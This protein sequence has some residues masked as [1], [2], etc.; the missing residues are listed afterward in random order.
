MHTELNETYHSVHG[1]IQESRYVFIEKGLEYWLT[2]NQNR[3]VNILEI[4][5]GTALNALLTLQ[6]ARELQVKI[7][8]AALEAYPLARELWGRLNY[9][10]TLGDAEMFEQMHEVP[11]DTEHLLTPA[12]LLKKY[13]T[14]L[15]DVKLLPSSFDVV[16]Y[17]A[18]AP[19]KQPEM[20]TLEM[21]QKVAEAIRPEG[22]FVTYCARGQLK[23]DLKTLGLRVETLTGPPGKKE[24]VRAVRN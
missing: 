23:R 4:G 16:Y 19:V 14:T 24:M 7:N 12:F 8:Y 9:S 2:S 18:F 3:D 1:A 10:D 17:D 5:F 20:W 21:L 6:K 13:Y 11:W 15:Q 22:V